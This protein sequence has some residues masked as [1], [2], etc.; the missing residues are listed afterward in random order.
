[1]FFKF[2]NYKMKDRMNLPKKIFFTAAVGFIAQFSSAQTVQEGIQNV[3]SHKYAKARD[4]YNQMISSNPDDADNYFY[5]GNT[6]L[7]QFDPNLEKDFP[8]ALKA[9]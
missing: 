8:S 1:M 7:T 9:I 3:D 5:L 6:Y 4:I 2:D